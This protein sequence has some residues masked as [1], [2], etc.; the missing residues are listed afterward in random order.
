MCHSG[1]GS[2]ASVPHAHAEGCMIPLWLCRICRI[3]VGP[4]DQTRQ[5]SDVK[6][7]GQGAASRCFQHLVDFPGICGFLGCKQ[8][9]TDAVL[10]LGNG[11]Q[12]GESAPWN[13]KCTHTNKY[14]SMR[15]LKYRK[16]DEQNRRA[17]N[18][19]PSQER[20]VRQRGRDQQCLG[21]LL[22]AR[23]RMPRLLSHMLCLAATRHATAKAGGQNGRNVS[24]GL[25]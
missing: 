11:W 14:Q 25:T 1:S 15:R 22:A 16:G 4:S 8:R 12:R 13:T 21:Q 9:W 23:P 2:Q 3:S 20:V 19:E 17:H 18:R 24:A 10:R 6:Q 7:V 5:A